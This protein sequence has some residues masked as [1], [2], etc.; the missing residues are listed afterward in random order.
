MRIRE[1]R[2]HGR[3]CSPRLSRSSLGSVSRWDIGLSIVGLVII[4][5]IGRW[6]YC[7]YGGDEGVDESDCSWHLWI[8]RN[9]WCIIC[10]V[11]ERSA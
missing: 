4:T 7:L 8:G 5:A 2:E 3:R 9:R 1:Y 11:C 10:E 6:R